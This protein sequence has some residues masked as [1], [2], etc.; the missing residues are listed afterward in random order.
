MISNCIK[1]YWHS[2]ALLLSLT[3]LTVIYLKAFNYPEK[4][5]N[6]L[7]YS[8][9]SVFFTVLIATDVYRWY[10]FGA[11]NKI[12]NKDCTLNWF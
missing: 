8:E 9:L 12:Y 2:N 4:V 11:N 6:Y 7:K 3:V 1:H 10:I 5:F